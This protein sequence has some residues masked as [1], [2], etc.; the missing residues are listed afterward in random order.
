[1]VVW[2]FRNALLRRPG[3]GE[4]DRRYETTDRL[5]CLGTDGVSD[6]QR[7]HTPLACPYSQQLRVSSTSSASK[8][9]PAEWS[10][11]PEEDPPGPALT[12]CTCSSRGQSSSHIHDGS[13]TSA[14]RR[15]LA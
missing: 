13:I 2:H 14:A 6:I 10:S 8:S 4:R 15:G 7:R 3:E 9:Y 11:R 1:M 12:C 5:T